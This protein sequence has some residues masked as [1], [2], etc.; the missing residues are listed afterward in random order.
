MNYYKEAETTRAMRIMRL[1]EWAEG[2]IKNEKNTT[3]LLDFNKEEEVLERIERK[4][5]FTHTFLTEDT[6]KSYAREI[7]SRLKPKYQTDQVQPAE[8]S[9]LNFQEG[10]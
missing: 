6:R 4:V 10:E 9:L 2:E 5:G 8:N 7:F 3:G 1:T